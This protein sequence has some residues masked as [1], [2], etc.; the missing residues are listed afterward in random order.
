MARKVKVGLV[1]TSCPPIP[2]GPGRVKAIMESMEAKTI[3]WIEKAGKAGVQILGLQEIFNTP[4]FCPAQDPE[5]CDTAEAVPGPTIER[6]QALSKK[7][8]MAMVV[9]IYEREMAGVY[10]NTAAVLDADGTYLG[11]YRKMHIPH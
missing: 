4:Y 11:K 7:Y 1:Q 10:Y 5:W 6:M 9:P 3:P 2:T 8:G